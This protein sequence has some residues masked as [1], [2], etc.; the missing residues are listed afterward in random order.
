MPQGLRRETFYKYIAPERIRKSINAFQLPAKQC[1]RLGTQST[2]F[3]W[4]KKKKWKRNKTF[5]NKVNML[6]KVDK[7]KEKI[8]KISNETSLNRKFVFVTINI[9]IKLQ[10]DTGSD[11]TIINEKTWRKMAKPSL[12]TTRKVACGV[13]GK[14]L[15]FFCEFDCNI[16]F[17]EKTKKAVVLVW[18]N[19]NLLERMVL[20]YL[21]FGTCQ[22]IYFCNQVSMIP[23]SNITA[24]GKFKSELKSFQKFFRRSRDGYKSKDEIWS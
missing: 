4:K 2:C 7:R 6:G 5:A 9:K 16:S 17:V 15:N 20:P 22:S 8:C 14:K 11:I 23:K 12:L 10:L 1:G 19:T 24:T 18:K 13:S 21:I 3:K